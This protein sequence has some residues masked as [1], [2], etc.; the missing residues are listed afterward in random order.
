MNGI[1][2]A[3][4]SNGA[5][6]MG[7][8]TVRARRPARQ[9]A[10]GAAQRGGTSG[11][12]N[13]IGAGGR[14]G[15]GAQPLGAMSGSIQQQMG[16]PPMPGQRPM[17]GLGGR[18]MNGAG[19]PID[20]GDPYGR[21]VSDNSMRGPAR[22]GM[23]PMPPMVG[24]SPMSG[25][26]GA[27]PGGQPPAGYPDYRLPPMPEMPPMPDWDGP[28]MAQPGQG[29][30][31]PGD[32]HFGSRA[33]VPPFGGRGPAGTPGGPGFGMSGPMS[34]PGVS[35]PGMSGPRGDGWPEN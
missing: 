13:A 1:A 27:P 20:P 29:Q 6:A 18:G 32:S 3:S 8:G 30:R 19:M 4:A 7:Q 5:Q 17:Q 14:M 24:M 10:S 2:G 23:P 34:R 31:G 28:P 16:V 12:L 35:G 11:Q 26:F 25:P 9:G 21:R 15:A 33:A 22:A